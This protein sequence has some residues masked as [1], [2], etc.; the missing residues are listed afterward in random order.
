MNDNNF[1]SIFE[2]AKWNLAEDEIVECIILLEHLEPPTEN[3]NEYYSLLFR[4]LGMNQDFRKILSMTMNCKTD[5]EESIIRAY[6]EV[7]I[8]FENSYLEDNIVN[9]SFIKDLDSEILVNLIG[10]LMDC[11]LYNAGEILFS[12]NSFK[13][14]EKDY[15]NSIFHNATSSSTFSFTLDEYSKNKFLNLFK[16]REEYF[17][18]QI[19]NE[20]ENFIYVPVKQ[21][22]NSSI[23]DLHISGD[24]T[25]GL[26]TLTKESTCFTSVFD[27]DIK[28]AVYDSLNKESAEFH[29][30]KKEVFKISGLLREEL[31]KYELPSFLVDSGNKGAHVWM[32]FHE[33]V[34]AKPLKSFLK[35]ILEK[36]TLPEE[37]H[38]DLFPAQE[39][40]KEN[41]LGN[42]IKLPLG[43][44]KKSGKRSLFLTENFI[45]FT[46]QNE[47]LNIIRQISRNQFRKAIESSLTSK[48]KQE[49]KKE[50]KRDLDMPHE[51]ER[52]LI[53][54][55]V[56]HSLVGK[57]EQNHFLEPKEEHVLIYVLGSLGKSGH[58]FCH[59]IFAK[60]LRY[61]PDSLTGKLKAVPPNPMS[62][63]KIRKH[64]KQLS[65]YVNCNCEFDL[66]DKEYPSPLKHCGINPE[67]KRKINR[68]NHFNKNVV[69]PKHYIPED[70][71][72]L[73]NKFKLL[74]TEIKTLTFKKETIEKILFK[75]SN[76][77]GVIKTELGDFII[78][79]DTN[80]IL[81]KR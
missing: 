60:T 3:L 57:I 38:I 54:C 31:M 40:L 13:E 65:E 22:L 58:V 4:A 25:L 46:N 75:M 19:K 16:G 15:L 62:C 1:H 61:N 8:D 56:I 77:T 14:S 48:N 24:L 37:I 33:P 55:S 66:E 80:K 72:R 21:T 68:Q 45:P 81:I 41:G 10:I 51:I 43:I 27:I 35:F 12:N 42:L 67:N 78:D 36:I 17:A 18:K 49:N 59:F 34:D 2:K 6:F 32:F 44:H 23:L 30:I 52:L 71:V 29:D 79:Q 20:N 11:G 9:I 39:R 47:G 63:P 76:G 53:G 28:K 7:L 73:I 26:Y 5:L 69:T 64:L 74:K 70:S 50:H